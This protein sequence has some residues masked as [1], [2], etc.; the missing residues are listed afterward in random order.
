M[1]GSR[2]SGITTVT[3]FIIIKTAGQQQG[4]AEHGFG[5]LVTGLGVTVIVTGFGVTGSCAGANLVG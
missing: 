3:T 1:S 4:T 2:S 5:L